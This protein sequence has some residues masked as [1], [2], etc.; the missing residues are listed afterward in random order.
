MFRIVVLLGQA[1]EFSFE[2]SYA[3]PTRQHVTTIND[4]DWAYTLSELYNYVILR[5]DGRGSGS[6]GRR[7]ESQM[8]KNFN[9]LEVEDQIDGV[10]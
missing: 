8:Y 7:F 9:N 2:C 3:G 5:I 4:P 10:K 1:C 6:R